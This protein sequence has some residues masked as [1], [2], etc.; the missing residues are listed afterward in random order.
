MIDD[1]PWALAAIRE[2][3]GDRWWELVALDGFERNSALL[4]GALRGRGTA[5]ERADLSP[6]FGVIWPASR[7]LADAVHAAGDLRGRRVLELGCGLALPSMVAAAAGAEV[8]ATDQ[9]PHAEAFL[10]RNLDRNGV[11]GVRYHRLDWRRPAGLPER[12]FDLVLAS[13]VLFARELPALVVATFHRY[14]APGGVGWLADPGRAW[15]PEAEDAARA[16]GLDV[17]VDV[18]EVVR[19][20]GRDEVFFL[21]LRRIRGSPS[22]PRAL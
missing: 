1:P 21:T 20:T 3:V 8:V 6:M 4:Y 15:L 14:L 5:E 19:A 17:E 2:R 7:A 16:A 11:S 10:R 12:A 18:A 22:S 9:H 13:D